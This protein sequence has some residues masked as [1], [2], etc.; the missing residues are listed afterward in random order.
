MNRTA[1]GRVLY[2]G[3]GHPVGFLPFIAAAL[4]LIKGAAAALIPKAVGTV[5]KLAQQRPAPR[6]AAPVPFPPPAPATPVAVRPVVIQPPPQPVVI[7]APVTPASPAMWPPHPMSYVRP[8][9]GPMTAPVGVPMPGMYPM[10][11]PGRRR[12][13]RVGRRLA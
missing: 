10:Y 9:F 5:A 12:V 4:P 6:S 1:Y 7:Q 2:D 13:R 3:L 11:L 8:F